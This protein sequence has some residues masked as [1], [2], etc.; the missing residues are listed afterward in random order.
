M[1]IKTY[2]AVESLFFY[3]SFLHNRHHHH[4]DHYIICAVTQPMKNA[5]TPFFTL[6]PFPHPS[7][8]R[9]STSS[10]TLS[11][12]CPE[13]GKFGGMCPVFA[14]NQNICSV[15]C[16]CKWIN[17]LLGRQGK[18]SSGGLILNYGANFNCVTLWLRSE[19]KNPSLSTHTHERILQSLAS[20]WAHPLN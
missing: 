6:S 17:S 16:F 1:I 3:N 5:L 2:T 12:C 20:R 15:K 19:K 11:H 10:H 13:P 7:T 18:W 9:S 14:R 8:H 4:K